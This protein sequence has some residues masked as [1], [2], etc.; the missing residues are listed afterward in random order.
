[1]LE[2]FLKKEDKYKYFKE[3]DISKFLEIYKSIKP[4]TSILEE[5]ELRKKKKLKRRKNEE[6]H[7]SILEY[8]STWPEE[9]KKR[10]G[11]IISKAPKPPSAPL[12]PKFQ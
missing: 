8:A 10:A 12:P 7:K 4:S 2:D 3:T 9:I 5:Y 6:E 1:M 11:D